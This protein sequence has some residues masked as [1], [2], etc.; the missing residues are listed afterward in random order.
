MM[1]KCAACVGTLLVFK[2]EQST[3]NRPIAS[4][5]WI[6]HHTWP[7]CECN[8]VYLFPFCCQYN[9]LWLLWKCFGEPMF[10]WRKLKHY[11]GFYRVI[12]SGLIW[13]ECC[14]FGEWPDVLSWRPREF[15]EEGIVSTPRQFSS[16]SG[17]SVSHTAL[18]KSRPL[19]SV[20]A[21]VR[22]THAWTSM[23]ARMFSK[24]PEDTPLRGRFISRCGE[25]YWG[26][27][28]WFSWLNEAKAPLGR[29]CDRLKHRLAQLSK[30]N[31]SNM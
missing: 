11:R 3:A 8:I 16:S 1:P 20:F 21:C 22:E 18:Q 24:S 12:W 5:V 29:V 28:S 10:D 2:M 4:C 7:S 23:H 13:S 17:L 14:G 27:V 15:M 26:V 19:G 31:A 30:L 9:V 6:I 25:A